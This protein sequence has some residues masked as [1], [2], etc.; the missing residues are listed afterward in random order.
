M[1]LVIAFFAL[2]LANAAPAG[3]TSGRAH[4]QAAESSI[5]YAENGTAPVAVFTAHD[6]DGDAIEWSLSGVDRSLFTIDGGVLAFREPPNYEERR[7]GAAS[8]NLYRVT[9]EASGGT[10]DVAVTVTD[11]DEAGVVSISRPQPQV[12]RPLSASLSDEDDGVAEQSWQWARSVDG[13]TWTDIEGAS[14]STRSPT[15]DDV[16]MYL[17]ATVTYSDKFGTGKTA[18]AVSANRVEARTLSNAAPSFADQDG[19]DTTP[20]IDIAL[21]VE[22]NAALGTAIGTV[23]ATDADGDVLFY[24]LLD[25]PD[26]RDAVGAARF[27]IDSA[28]GQIRV[29]KVLGADDGEREDEDSTGLAGSPPLPDGEDAADPRNSKYVLRVKVSDPSTASATVNVIVTVSDVNEP[30]IFGEDPPTLLRV[31]ENADPPIITFGDGDTPVVAGTYAAFDLDVDETGPH[32][33]DD[34]SYSYSVSGPDNDVLAFDSDGVLSFRPE[35]KIDYEE[36][37][38]YSITVVARSGVGLRRLTATLDVTIEVADGE[39]PGKVSLSLRE[40][41]VEREVQARVSDPDGGVRIKGWVWDRSDE[42]TVDDGGTPSAECRDDPGTGIDAVGGWT[43]IDGASS[44]VYTAQATDVGRCLRATAVYTDNV[45]NPAGAGDERLTVV[46]EAPVQGRRPVNAAPHFLDGTDGTSR[47]VTENTE[48]GH[49]IG[50]P[51]S[52]HDEDGD[53]LIY[54]LGGPDAAS[55]DISRNNGQ[56]KTKAPLD[57]EAR[58][59]HTVVVTATDPSGAAS[60]TQVTIHVR[61]VDEPAVIAG[62][63]SITYAENGLSPVATF[64]ADD[65]DGG[66]VRWSLGGRDED[67]FTMAGGVLDFRDPPDYEF[68]RSAVEGVSLAER[69]LYRVTIEASGG[70]HDVTVTVKDL[71]EEGAVSLSGLQPQVARP[72]LASLWDEDE[73]VTALSWQWARSV[74]GTAWTDIE[75]ATSPRRSPTPEDV[76]MY[77]RATVTYSDR[78]GAGKTVSVETAYPVEPMTLANAAPSFADQGENE[79]TPYI[80]VVRTVAENTAAGIPIGEPVSATDADEDVLYYEL[81]DTPDLEDEDGRARFTID[82]TAGQIRVAEELGA[83]AGQREDED[84]TSLSGRPLL[85]EGEDA[86]EADNSEYVLRVRVSDPSTASDTVNV[87]VRVVEVNEPPLFDE[88]APTALRVR[89][90]VVPPVITLEDGETPVGVDTYAVIDE[91]G[92]VTGSDGYD[93]TSY[94]YSVSGS[95]SPAFAFNSDGV[96]SFRAAWK[97]D[98]ETKSS[99]SI[100]IVARSGQGARDMNSTL[101]VTIEVVDTEDAGTVSLSQRQPQVG[102]EI[103]ATLSD[104]DGGVNLTRWVW[105][106]SDETP[107]AACRS[108]T[109]GWTPIERAS[110]AVYAPQPADVGRC[111]RVTAVYTDELDDADQRA[112]A[113]LEVTVRGP[114]HAPIPD[115][116]DDGGFVNAAPVFPDQDFLT[117]GDQSDRTSRTV[118]ENTRAGQNIGDPVS[119]IDADGDLLIYTLSGTDARSFGISRNDGQLRTRA[120]LNYE[121]KNSYTVAVTATDPF[122]A[123]DSIEVTINVTDE[124]DPAV[125]TVIPGAADDGS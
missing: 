27:T 65:Q 98:F 112:K 36:Q 18:S 64:S 116:E 40:P 88:D 78:F 13:T 3:P 56:L 108:Y 61:G 68:P 30:P 92:S 114:S 119:A 60:A 96:L 106:R 109:G 37:A 67:L 80:N 14:P 121:E 58:R 2:M 72:F 102:I 26:L 101:D 4:A 50:K 59:S 17:R 11:V 95:D 7:S 125:I 9:V 75:G 29:G 52:A 77:L 115:P 25:T 42:I 16:D 71:D 100:T 82:S 6:Q 57:Y 19:D 73:G 46:T 31:R 5:E 44:A 28:T 105:E 39:D 54:T 93:D 10:Y 33:Y 83:D 43:P 45:E 24:E 62:T 110:S 94:T 34:R 84:S 85:P 47:R 122:G 103:L 120:S 124:D 38:S 69:N 70:A 104:P 99:Y 97:P 8:G 41:Q 32:P 111:L 107:P 1:A 113:V 63:R 91:D 74:D 23:S 49:D 12:D 123:T 66:L 15:P 118:P 21:S 79:D 55:F 87:I 22:E 35:H 86:D 90:N 51:V 76:G 89:E 48:A 53:L 81:L 20:Y 117:E